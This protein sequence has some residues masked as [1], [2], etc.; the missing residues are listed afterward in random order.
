VTV[1]IQAILPNI[2]DII[3]SIDSKGG[4]RTKIDLKGAFNLLRIWP[5]SEDLTTFIT[6]FGKFAYRVIP[7]GL[8]NA[9]GFFQDT[10][11]RIFHDLIGNGLWVY[12][13]DILIYE[14][15]PSKHRELI[16]EVLTRLRNYGFVLSLKKCQFE[17]KRVEFLGFQLEEGRIGMIKS[18]VSA[19][20]DFPSLVYNRS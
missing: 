16:R 1:P 20:L 8:R 10:M 15:D 19:I 6:K 18:K 5:Q 7:F 4:R 3:S 11:N 12:I 13:D 14:P 17:D 2:Q 9:P